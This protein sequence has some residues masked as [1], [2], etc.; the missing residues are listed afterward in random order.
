MPLVR[1]SC[2]RKTLKPGNVCAAVSM[3]QPYINADGERVA[4]HCN[5]HVPSDMTPKVYTYAISGPS[6]SFLKQGT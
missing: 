3:M 5:K 2:A 4:K 1:P 6:P